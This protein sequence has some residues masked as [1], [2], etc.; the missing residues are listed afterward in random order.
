VS[1]DWRRGAPRFQGEN[2]AANLALVEQDLTLTAKEVE[3]L[4][5]VIPHGAAAGARYSPAMMTSVNR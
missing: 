4:G 2:F 3:Q 1:T 5:H